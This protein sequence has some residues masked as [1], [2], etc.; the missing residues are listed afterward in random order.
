MRLYFRRRIPD[1][2][3]ALLVESGSREVSE[4]LLTTLRRIHGEHITIDLVSCYAGIPAGF[5]PEGPAGTS[6]YRVSEYQGRAGLNRLVGELR[7]RYPVVGIICSA[8]P[9]MTKWKWALLAKLPAKIFIVNE[10]GDYFWLD[11]SNWRITGYFFL[12]R[13]GLVGPGAA[14]AVARLV[15]VPFTLAYLLLYAAGI[16]IRRACYRLVN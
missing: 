15:F 2:D 5:A 1:F 12:F 14:G 9:I 4:R 10:N 11:Y 16:H 3:R 13:A 8:E 7:N 6:V